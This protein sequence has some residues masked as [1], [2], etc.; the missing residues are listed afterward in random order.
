MRSKVLSI[1][2]FGLLLLCQNGQ[3][4]ELTFLYSNDTGGMIDPCPT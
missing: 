4:G 3:A 2:M 1:L